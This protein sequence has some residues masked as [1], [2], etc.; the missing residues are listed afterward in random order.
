LVRVVADPEHF[1]RLDG[2]LAGMRDLTSGA[3]RAHYG[4]IG[5]LNL[6]DG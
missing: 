5:H 1:E 2:Q 6:T 4:W 3:S